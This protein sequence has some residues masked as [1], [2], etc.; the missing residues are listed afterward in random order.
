MSWIQNEEAV[1]FYESGVAKIDDEKLVEAIPDF[2]KAIELDPNYL[3]AFNA[4][5]FCY[6]VLKNYKKAIEDYSKVIEHRPEV[7]QTY[8]D[9]GRTLVFSYD[10]NNPNQEDLKQAIEDLNKVIAS[11]PD[12]YE[13]WW[14]IGAAKMRCD[15]YNEYQAIS[16]LSEAIELNPECS[17]ALFDRAGCFYK[18]RDLASALEDYKAAFKRG[19]GSAESHLYCGI[20]R[21]KVEKDY[22][23]AIEDF[24]LAI[25]LRPDYGDAYAIRGDSYI[26]IARYHHAVKDLTEALKH[27]LTY[28]MQA[29]A[30]RALAKIKLKNYAS[31]TEDYTA[32]IEMAPENA[33]LYSNRGV[34]LIHNG[35]KKAA[36]ADFDKAI[37][38]APETA[39]PYM[40]RGMLKNT[41]KNYP[42]AV[43]DLEKAR[44]ISPD[45]TETLNHLGRAYYYLAEFEKAREVT[46]RIL[47]IDPNCTWAKEALQLIDSQEAKLKSRK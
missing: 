24:T 14:F 42:A 37:Q 35:D 45:N 9:R 17:G 27:D 41:L 3:N 2:D 11:M 34:A 33:E 44:S 18:I 29:M 46:K 21:E 1:K 8:L 20:C 22:T 12:N 4:R 39:R 31:A 30:N 13:P 23:G 5:A 36:M 40:L 15:G 28:P 32:A 47:K 25:Q 43:V 6:A 10:P 38:L 19:S 26:K 7:A 16:D